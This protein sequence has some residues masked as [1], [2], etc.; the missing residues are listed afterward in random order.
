MS[1]CTLVAGTVGQVHCKGL[2]VKL[3]LVLQEFIS[4]Q[5]HFLL[6]LVQIAAGGS[7]CGPKHPLASPASGKLI[8]ELLQA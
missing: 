3:N 2:S 5:I 7:C 8:N 1:H 4:L 6:C